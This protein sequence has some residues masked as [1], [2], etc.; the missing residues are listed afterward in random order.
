MDRVPSGAPTGRRPPSSGGGSRRCTGPARRRSAPRRPAVRLTP[1]SARADAQRDGVR[2][3]APWYAEHRVLPYLRHARDAGSST[4]ARRA[5]SSGW[6]ARLP[7]RGEPA[8]P[9]AVCTATSGRATCSGRADGAWLIDP[10]AHGGHRETDLAMLALFGCPH[11]DDVLAAYDEAAPLAPGGASGCRFTS[12]SPCS[13][14]PCC[15]A[16]G[17]RRRGRRGPGGAA[18]RMRTE[19]DDSRAMTP[20]SLTSRRPSAPVVEDVGVGGVVAGCIQ[21]VPRQPCRRNRSACRRPPASGRPGVARC[22][23]RG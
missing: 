10:A 17:T 11:L 5:S 21:A 15:S 19:T 7:E 13:C 20:F 22:S 23:R 12:C 3:G 1:G 2:P 8:E 4:R 6:C 9:P 16:A 18:P 14:T